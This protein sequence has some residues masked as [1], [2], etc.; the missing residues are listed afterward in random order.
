MK[1]ILRVHNPLDE[2]KATEPPSVIGMYS[3]KNP[4]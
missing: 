4:V 2:E 1:R 3:S